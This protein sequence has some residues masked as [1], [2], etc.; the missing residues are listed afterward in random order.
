MR[1]AVLES[2]NNIVVQEIAS[3]EPG[4][5]QVRVRVCYTGVCGSDVPRVLE[6]RV[7]TFPLVLGH[8]FS[9]YVDAVGEGVDEAFVG[10]LIAGIPLEPC[11]SCIDCQNG[12]FSLC[13]QYGFIGSRSFGSMAECVVVP[14]ENV[15]FVDEGVT[16]LQ[17]AFF[18]PAT[19]ALHGIE[20]AN[21]KPGSSAIVLGGGTIG[22]L[23]AQALKGYGVESVV[24][25]Y[26]RDH[27]LAPLK[28]AGL[29]SA[30]N[31]SKEGWRDEACQLAG[32]RGFDYVFDTAGT[33]ET[34]LDAFEMAG[35]RAT[36]CFVGT[37]KRDVCFTVREWEHINRKELLVTG[38]WM[39]YSAPWP[40]VEWTK[41]SEFFASGIMRIVDEM[42]DTVYPLSQTQEA[43]QRFAIPGGV[44]GKIIIDSR[45]E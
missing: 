23:L 44:N 31:T 36:V 3:P 13:K 9:G 20:L 35:N 4:K 19:V 33:P 28:A 15:Y 30:V 22:I 17:A 27:K 38:S 2:T 6:G 18:E 21:V 34:I 43:M 5:G 41:T 26:R 11:G 24:V 1:A 16:E 29:E 25:T 10:R 8:E 45:G 7:H 14:F 40:G 37:P 12:N 32:G 39:S 42:V